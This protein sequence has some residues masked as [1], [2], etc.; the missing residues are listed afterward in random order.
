V[1]SSSS[2]EDEEA[3]LCLKAFVT[4]SMSSSSSIKGNNYYQLLEAF[5]ETHE[6]ANRLALSHNRLKGFNNWL[7]NIVKTLE[8]ELKKSKVDFE[9]LDLI[10]KNFTCSCDSKFCENCENLERKIHYLL[11][12]MDKLTTGKSNF[13]NVLASQNCVFGKAGLGFYP[14][15]KE[16]GISK[17]FLSVLEK[18]PIKRT[19]QL[20][21]TCFYC[22]KRGHSVKSICMV[23]RINL[24]QNVPSSLRD[25]ML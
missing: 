7:E 12:T 24:T 19:K 11:K 14:Q 10:Y 25:Q 3:N 23:P 1:S 16:N 6:E 8:E 22:M 2:L 9:N 17:P 5:N 18:Q 13:E 20:L 21:I 4:S 15:S